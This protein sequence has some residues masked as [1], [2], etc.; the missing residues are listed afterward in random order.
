M[1]TGNAASQVPV[2]L[3]V[4][5]I[6]LSW[7]SLR[8]IGNASPEGP[9]FDGQDTVSRSLSGM[10]RAT[11]LILLS[12]VSALPAMAAPRFAVVQ[13]TEVYR[14]LT[15]TQTM[16][17]EIQKERAEILK[18]ERAVHLRNLLEEMK[19]LQ[20]QLQAKRDAPVDDTI[21]KLAQQAAGGPDAA[22]GVPDF[23]CG[24]EKG[25]QPEDGRGHENLAREDP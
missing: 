2:S 19:A 17:A 22:G 23:R 24:E 7:E 25:D 1:N 3:S 14:N 8:M 21:R 5:R 20:A 15:S 11:T 9:F 18:D 12:L 13:V 16:L 10:L 4:G 6:G